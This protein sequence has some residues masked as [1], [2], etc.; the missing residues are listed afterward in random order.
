MAA[1]FGVGVGMAGSMPP[2]R[3]PISHATCEGEHADAGDWRDQIADQQAGAEYRYGY[4][5][6]RR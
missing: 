3:S 6:N 2:E 1:A 4:D 5:D